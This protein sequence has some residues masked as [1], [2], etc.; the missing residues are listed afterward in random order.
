MYC[1]ALKEDLVQIP[2]TGNLLIDYNVV[3]STGK[4]RRK[5]AVVLGGMIV[6]FTQEARNL[7]NN[8]TLP[9]FITCFLSVFHFSDDAKQVQF[10]VSNAP[11]IGKSPFASSIRRLHGYSRL[12]CVITHR[13]C[14]WRANLPPQWE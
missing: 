3:N 13:L 12:E 7:F 5:V 8:H 11:E 2:K 9:F 6:P 14:A 4:N 10:C 1:L